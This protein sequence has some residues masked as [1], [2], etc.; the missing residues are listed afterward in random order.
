MV[1][2]KDHFSGHSAEYAKYRP[3]Y[4]DA[5]FEWLASLTPAHDLAWD[6]GT[7]SGQA[8]LGL[9]HHFEAVIASDAAQAQLHNAPPHPRVTY[10][11]MPAERSDLADASVDLTTVAQAIHWFDFDRFYAEVRRVLKPTGVI[12][13]WT[14]G[15]NRIDPQI[16]VIVRRYYSEIV[17]SYWP[18]EREHVDKNYRTIPF[19][20]PEVSAPPLSMHERWSLD[21]LLGYLGTWSASKLYAQ[22]R[23]ENPTELIRAPLARVW[24]PEAQRVV[25]WPIHLR[26]GRLRA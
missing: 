24:G 15:L 4:P 13:A 18:P 26:V 19:P 10:K 16:D 17:R 25:E 11:V 21:D 23:G 7:G 9:A 1:E 20:F 12:A 2:F 6:V 22:A 3:G 8:A 14:Y 5:L